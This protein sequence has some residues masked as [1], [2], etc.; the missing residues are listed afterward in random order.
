MKNF[1]ILQQFYAPRNNGTDARRKFKSVL[2][3]K[4]A[5]IAELNLETVQFYDVEYIYEKVGIALI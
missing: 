3:A 4:T 2:F 1:V 5:I